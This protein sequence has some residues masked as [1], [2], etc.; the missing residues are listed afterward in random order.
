M[1]GSKPPVV[2]QELLPWFLHFPFV[3]LSRSLCP[4]QDF[5]SATA[6]V[7]MVT[8]GSMDGNIVD[9]EII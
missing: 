3:Q 4:F 2:G 8:A 5:D 7:R 9:Q 1:S 6:T